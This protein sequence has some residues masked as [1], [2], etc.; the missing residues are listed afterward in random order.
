MN[1]RP[2]TPAGERRAHLEHP[3]GDRYC[4]TGIADFG[5]AARLLTEGRRAFAGRKTMAITVDLKDADCVNSAGLALLL[6][7]ALWCSAQ[8]IDLHY[9]NAAPALI[10]AAAIH[11]V[12]EALPMGPWDSGLDNGADDHGLVNGSA[13]RGSTASPASG[14]HREGPAAAPA[15]PAARR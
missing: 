14:P 11:G 3:C 5:N 1:L 12:G 13:T 2:K 7:W 9:C 4:L 15:L 10:R 8:G 6:E